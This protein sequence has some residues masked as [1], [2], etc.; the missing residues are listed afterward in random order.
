MSLRRNSSEAVGEHG[1]DSEISDHPIF[2]SVIVSLE[3]V[4]IPAREKRFRAIIISFE[5]VFSDS[6]LPDQ[7]ARVEGGT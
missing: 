4:M 3:S 1:W 6:R 5:G 7:Q 2:R